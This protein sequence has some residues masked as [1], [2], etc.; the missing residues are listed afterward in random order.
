MHKQP[1]STLSTTINGSRS[2]YIT[3]NK[4]AFLSVETKLSRTKNIS[5]IFFN[6]L[7][8]LFK[9]VYSLTKRQEKG[10][11]LFFKMNIAHL[12]HRLTLRT[13]I[14]A[15]AKRLKSRFVQASFTQTLCVLTIHFSKKNNSAIVIP[16]IGGECATHCNCFQKCHNCKQQKNDSC[17]DVCFRG[18]L[19]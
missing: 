2:C 17:R 6:R 13:L 4:F 7:W 8:S 15:P 11:C 5:K 12:T 3:T 19:G 9:N 14:I 10:V 18:N 16:R 1:G